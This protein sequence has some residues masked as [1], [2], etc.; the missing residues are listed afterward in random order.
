[1]K[2]RRAIINSKCRRQSL[3][4][5]LHYPDICLKKTKQNKEKPFSEQLI[6]IPNS[7]LYL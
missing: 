4:V 2:D 7:K 3:S 6:T 1:M 5:L